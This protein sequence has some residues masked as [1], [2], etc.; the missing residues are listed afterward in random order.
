[1][2]WVLATVGEIA[3]AAGNATNAATLHAGAET[4]RT[5]IGFVHPAPRARELE[6]ECRHI[7]DTLG[8]DAFNTAWKTGTTLTIDELAHR[9]RQ[10]LDA[11][12]TTDATTAAQQPVQAT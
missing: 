2:T 4:L 9:A 8:A 3:W 12:A 6:H 10:V 1:M 7:R 5:Q 11:V